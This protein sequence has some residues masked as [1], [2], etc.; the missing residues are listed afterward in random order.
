[1]LHIHRY[2]RVL[3]LVVPLLLMTTHP[4]PS[5]AQPSDNDRICALI[6]NDLTQI[7][8]KDAKTTL[9]RQ[10]RR[11]TVALKIDPNRAVFV[12]L[13]AHERLGCPPSSL[14]VPLSLSEE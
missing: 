6:T 1:M 7:I 5:L 4:T 8:R 12:L 2:A 14:L 9:W 10:T 3:P 11:G 13:S